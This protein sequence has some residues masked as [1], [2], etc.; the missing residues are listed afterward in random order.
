MK[1]GLL[2]RANAGEIVRSYPL[3][4]QEIFSMAPRVPVFSAL[5]GMDRNGHSTNQTNK[6]VRSRKVP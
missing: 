1:L 3:E 2:Y 6:I 5:I 4:G